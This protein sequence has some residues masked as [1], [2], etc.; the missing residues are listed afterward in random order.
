MCLLMTDSRGGAI[1]RVLRP[2]NQIF[3]FYFSSTYHRFANGLHI[4]LGEPMGLL[5][6][7]LEVGLNRLDILNFAAY[8]HAQ[9]LPLLF[10]EHLKHSLSVRHPLHGTITYDIWQNLNPETFT[11]A[12]HLQHLDIPLRCTSPPDTTK[13]RQTHCCGRRF[14]PSFQTLRRSD[15]SSISHL[16]PLRKTTCFPSAFPAYLIWQWR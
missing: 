3:R 13:H 9:S 5:D 8:N 11:A 15:Y 2:A 10:A 6:H 4:D 7:R 16:R 14:L 12:L 1:S